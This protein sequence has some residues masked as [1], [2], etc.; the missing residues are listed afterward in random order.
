MASEEPGPGQKDALQARKHIATLRRV[1][2]GIVIE[3]R[4]CPAHK[5]V[6]GNEKADEWAKFAAEEPDARG[7]EWLEYSDCGGALD[8]ASQIARIHQAGD[9]REETGG[10]ATVGW[11]QEL[12]KEV[13]DAG[14]P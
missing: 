2:P 1:R 14:E 12:Q 8:A 5:G 11:G 9:L 3:V 4:W 6:A 13:Q 10:D 7:V